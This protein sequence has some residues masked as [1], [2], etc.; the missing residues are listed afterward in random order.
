MTTIKKPTL[1][2]TLKSADTEETIDL[3]FYRPI[4]YWWALLFRKM[5]VHP[6]TVTV[7][8]IFLGVAAGVFFYFDNIYYNIIGMLLLVWANSYDS[9]DGQLARMT[10]QKSRIGRILDG[11]A[12]DFWFISIYVAICLRLTPEWG[13]WIWALAVVAGYSHSKQAA[14]ADYYRNIHLFFLKGEA[15][16][17]LDNSEQQFAEFR[18]LPWKGNLF[19]KLY[20]YLYGRYTAGQE[21][22]SP[23]FQR[24]FRGVREK[25]NKQIPSE[26]AEAFRR[27]S[28]PLMKHTNTL[29]FNT[30]VIVLFISLFLNLPWIYFIFELTLL[31]G[32]LVYMIRKHEA[33]SKRLYNS[34]VN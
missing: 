26:L 33:L 5:G 10:G 30:R 11:V 15:G 25:Y 28:K 4:G 13:V 2:S 23:N 17:E 18:V 19:M 6:N 3:L 21:S 1:E 16:S 20:Y 31:N 34:F 8:S 14:M 29:S 9:A 7:A 24:F 32:L 22:Y 12:G 27:G